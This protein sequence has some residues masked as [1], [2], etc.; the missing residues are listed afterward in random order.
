[1]LYLYMLC[2]KYKGVKQ[3]RILPYFLFLISNLDFTFAA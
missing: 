1:M 3:V 2:P